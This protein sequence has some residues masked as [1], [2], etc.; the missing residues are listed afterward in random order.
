[1]VHRNGLSFRYQTE[2]SIHS[3]EDLEKVLQDHSKDAKGVSHPKLFDTN[4]QQKAIRR[5]H[6]DHLLT[7][8]RVLR[9]SAA[10]HVHE[11]TAEGRKDVA[12]RCK[13]EDLIYYWVPSELQVRWWWW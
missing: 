13:D 9:C 1:M 3:R 4:E 12:K 7:T 8:G 2:F 5:Q 11:A 6:I 10:S